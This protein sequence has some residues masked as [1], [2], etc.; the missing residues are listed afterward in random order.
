MS[1]QKETFGEQNLN[2]GTT[3]NE[4]ALLAKIAGRY[5]EAESLYKKS[6]SILKIVAGE[7]DL[8]Y[9]RILNNL[10]TLYYQTGKYA[11]TEK[12]FIEVVSIK[13]SSRRNPS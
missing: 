9:L 10:A 3:L 7:E 8:D 2:Y 4:L 1:L 5:A 13:R 6:L 11:L 12:I